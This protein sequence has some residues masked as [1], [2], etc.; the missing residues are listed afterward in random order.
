MNSPEQIIYEKKTSIMAIPIKINNQKT[1]Q[2]SLKRDTFD[3]FQCS[4][5]NQF[6]VNLKMRMSAYNSL[7]I[8]DDNRN[9]E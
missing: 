7:V 9:S 8:N 1:N 2:Y 5:P 4:P 6:M 3:P